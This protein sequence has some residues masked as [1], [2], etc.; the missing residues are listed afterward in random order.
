M[1]SSDTDRSARGAYNSLVVVPHPLLLPSS[2]CRVIPHDERVR[3]ARLIL[4][5]EEEDSSFNLITMVHFAVGLKASL[6]S[7][8]TPRHTSGSPD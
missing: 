5:K 3:L 7:H 2:T 4:A 8:S 1:S 6:G